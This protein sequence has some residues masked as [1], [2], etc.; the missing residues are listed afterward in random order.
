MEI[1]YFHFH[2]YYIH[3]SRNNPLFYL[4]F[5]LGFGTMFRELLLHLF[6]NKIVAA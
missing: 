1:P 3:I 6:K 2:I 4:I 5:L